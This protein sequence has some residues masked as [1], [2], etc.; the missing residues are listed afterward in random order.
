MQVPSVCSRLLVACAALLLACTA[1]IGL[2][3]RKASAQPIAQIDLLNPAGDQ[4]DSEFGRHV[5]VLPN[6][7]I[8]VNDPSYDSGPVLDAGAV[9]LF[10]GTTPCIDQHADRNRQRR[11]CWRGG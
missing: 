5:T 3:S 1:V 10:N 7:N 2:V 9:Y 6:G 4:P 11:P 8:V